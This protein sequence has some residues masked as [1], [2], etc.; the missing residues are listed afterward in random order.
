MRFRPLLIVAFLGVR[1]WAQP[2]TLAGFSDEGS[3]FLYLNEERVGRL[4]F[5]WKADGTFESKGVLSLGGQSLSGSMVLTPDGEGRWTKAVLEDPSRKTVWEREGKTYTFTSP[6]MSGN[7][8]WPEDVLTF[9]TWSPPLISQALRRF[10]LTAG[11]TQTLHVLVL[12]AKVF[13]SADLIVERQDTLERSVGG[14][15]LKLTRWVYAPP[16]QEFH[17]LADQNG[18]G[19][20][21]FR[22]DR[23]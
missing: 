16:G 20:P 19:L 13:N 21:G 3:F 10:D 18:R 14:R 23:I 2:A 4:T 1:A 8:K 7:G 5:Q 17:V 11:A 15:S 12:N 22:T 9:E 6:D